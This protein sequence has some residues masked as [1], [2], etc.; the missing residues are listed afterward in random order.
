MATGAPPSPPPIAADPSPSVPPIAAGP[1][2]SIGVPSDPIETALATAI[3][4][5][6]RAGRF[7]VVAQLARELEARRAARANVVDLAV[8]RKRRTR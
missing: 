3:V 7:E 1:A 6:T 4:E 2:D 5:A 8:E